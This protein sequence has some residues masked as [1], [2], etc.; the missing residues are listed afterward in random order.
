[1]STSPTSNDPLAGLLVVTLEQAVAAPLCSARLRH[2]GARVIKIERAAGDFARN[3]D[4][5]ALGES[6]YFTW[7]NQGKESLVLDIKAA[8]DQN[9]LHSI[10]A[11]ADVFIQNLAPGALAKLSL[12]SESLRAQYP[13]LI[14][15]DI[16]GY[17]DA[18]AARHLK[19]Y[20]LLVQAE[21]GLIS[22][23]GGPGEPG[24]VGI[25]LCDIGTGVS[26]HAAI[27][28]ALIQRGITGQGSAVKVS[29]FDVAAEWMTVPF[30]HAAHGNGAPE[31]AGLHHP[32]IA[33][34]GAYRT[35]DKVATLVSIQN[36]REWLRFCESVLLDTEV[37]TDPLFATNNLRIQN[38]EALDQRI[39][40]AIGA[41]DAAAFRQ[42]LIDGNIAYG[43]LNSVEDLTRHVA[44]RQLVLGTT[45]GK[46]LSTPAHP[47]SRKVQEN[48]RTPAIGEHTD[49]IKR[50]FKT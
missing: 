36:E 16:S 13:R 7:L 27:L 5:A 50:Q 42:R 10:L 2:A 21:S 31:R 30:I 18:E 4:S 34:Y 23:S 9:L 32:S 3:Y 14:T 43:G 22:V 45:E 44:L 46:T 49:A 17:G 12:D 41:L 29:L 19:A 25:S 37:A 35:A 28:E 15:C 38:R 40:D 26:A 20:D 6:S 39:Y 1:M 24:R 48:L 8:T 33:P 11:Q 47:W